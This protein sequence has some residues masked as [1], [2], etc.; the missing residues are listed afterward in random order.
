MADPGRDGIE[1]LGDHPGKLRLPSPKALAQCLEAPRG[2]RLDAGEV[3]NALLHGLVLPCLA[4]VFPVGASVDE[5][6]RERSDL[7]VS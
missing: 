6:A 2:L 7:Y 1:P 4:G 5:A 3:G